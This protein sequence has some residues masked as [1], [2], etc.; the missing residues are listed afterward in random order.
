MKNLRYLADRLGSD[1][2]HGFVLYTGTQG[3][4]LED[5]RFS[6]I[7]VSALWGS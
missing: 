1:F 3:T 2:R 4:R 5:D 7:P 6:A